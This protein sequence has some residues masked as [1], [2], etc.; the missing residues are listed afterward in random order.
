ME[1][2]ELFFMATVVGSLLTIQYQL[3][4]LLKKANP[5]SDCLSARSEKPKNGFQDI[6]W[7]E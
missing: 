6:S 2:I 4:E 1:P 7:R 3:H 5:P